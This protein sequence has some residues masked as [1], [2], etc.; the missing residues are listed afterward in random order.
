[1]ESLATP[2]QNVTN[3]LSSLFSYMDRLEE[4]EETVIE[5]LPFASDEEVIQTRIYATRMSHGGWRIVCACDAVLLSRQALK[6]GRGC[7]DVE[8]VGRVEAAKQEGERRKITDRQVRRNAQIYNT[9]FKPKGKKKTVEIN[10]HSLLDDKQFY[11]E[12][13]RAPE[14]VK[15]IKMFEKEKSENPNF[16][17]A[18]A[19]RLV[20]KIKEDRERVE[21]PDVKNYIDPDFMG[22]LLEVEAALLSFRNRC[23][24]PEFS[25][26]LDSWIRATRFERARTPQKDYEAVRDQ[27]DRLASTVEE[28][29]EEVYLAPERI[30]QICEQIVKT[31]PE[32]YEWRPIGAN[33]DMARGSRALGIFRKDSPHYES[34][35]YA[36]TVD[37]ED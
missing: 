11:E 12:A 37:W 5:L 9:F 7:I 29:A 26:R 24:R 16:T 33:T 21:I 35:G 25:I 32:R 36:P 18:D 4:F 10:H 1:M 6:G 34:N 8:K 27:V 17:P 15:A 20:R 14:P 3:Q 22:F 31:E 13:L 19:G 23:A 28:I 2:P 30:R